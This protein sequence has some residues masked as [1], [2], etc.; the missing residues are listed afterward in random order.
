MA[1]SADFDMKILGKSR[2]GFKRVAA[3]TVD[4]DF[5]VVGMDFRLHEGFP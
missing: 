2:A 3:A 4:F 5:G 1:C